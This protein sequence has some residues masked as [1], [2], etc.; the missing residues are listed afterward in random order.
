LN[1]LCNAA[2]HGKTRTEFNK[3]TCWLPLSLAAI[4]QCIF[5]PA[6]SFQS[7]TLNK[8]NAS[9]CASAGI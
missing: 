6:A 7:M 1:S 3:S 9:G 2:Q 5:D 4:R 8:K